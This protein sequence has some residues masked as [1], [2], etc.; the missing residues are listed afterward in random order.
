[1]LEI[2]IGLATYAV[3][4]SLLQWLLPG[5]IIKPEELPHY[6]VTY[7]SQMQNFV[8]QINNNGG[9]AKYDMYSGMRHGNMQ[10]ALRYDEIFDWLLKQ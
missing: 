9:S 10:G 1:M 3:A 7:S 8:G 6:E 4:A 2:V 5:G